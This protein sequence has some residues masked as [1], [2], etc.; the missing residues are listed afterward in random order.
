MCTDMNS[1]VKQAIA[2]ALYEMVENFKGSEP[3]NSLVVTSYY[4]NT[5]YYYHH[6]FCISVRL[7]YF[8]NH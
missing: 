1:V 8:L 7:R 4:E 3:L 2:E 6:I 5:Q